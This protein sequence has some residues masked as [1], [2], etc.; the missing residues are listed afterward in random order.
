VGASAIFRSH[1]AGRQDSEAVSAMGVGAPK[2]VLL[3]FDN[4]NGVRDWRSPSPTRGRPEC[5][6]SPFATTR[7]RDSHREPHSRRERSFCIQ[8]DRSVSADQRTSG[9]HR[10]W[11]ER[12]RGPGPS[13]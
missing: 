10:D 12:G 5:F 1:T 11:V 13:V 6:P 3:P 7:E 9:H 4:R 2:G 8:F